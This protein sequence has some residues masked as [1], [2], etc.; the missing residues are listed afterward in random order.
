M[1]KIFTT[2]NISM[3]ER[4]IFLFLLFSIADFFWEEKNIPNIFDSFRYFSKNL[5]IVLV[6]TYNYNLT[7]PAIHT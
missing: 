4:N 6:F 5:V 3:I 2:S 7:G 1:C